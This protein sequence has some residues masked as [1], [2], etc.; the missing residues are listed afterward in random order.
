MKLV[1]CE[2]AGEKILGAVADCCYEDLQ[3]LR[4]IAHGL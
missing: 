1:S 4:E 3:S 2:N